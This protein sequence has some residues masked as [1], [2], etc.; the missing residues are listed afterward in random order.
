MIMYEILYYYM[1]LCSS[2]RVLYCKYD[3]DGKILRIGSN[4]TVVLLYTHTCAY[5]VVFLL[6][7]DWTLDRLPLR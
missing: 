1:V 3:F 4:A 7:P 2:Y 5:L 6:E